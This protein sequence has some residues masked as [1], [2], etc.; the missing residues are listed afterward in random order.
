[1]PPTPKLA[2]RP[3]PDVGADALRA[4]ALALLPYL[5]GL[6][7]AQHQ[8]GELVDVVTFVPGPPRSVRR[9]ARGGQIEGAV[10]VGRRWLAPR[11]S[12]EAWLRAAGPRVVP[13]PASAD[14]L[15]GLRMRLLRTSGERRR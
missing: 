6:L 8:G 13:A 5:L 2:P 14:D 10:K 12:V 3:S 9:A 11:S 7:D 4:L 15:D 1:M